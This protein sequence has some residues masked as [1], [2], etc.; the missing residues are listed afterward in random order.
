M[1]PI[2]VLSSRCT[3]AKYFI[4]LISHASSFEMLKSQLSPSSFQVSPEVSLRISV[5]SFGKKLK[6]SFINETITVALH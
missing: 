5:D 6:E 4:K 1:D 2:Y 3:L